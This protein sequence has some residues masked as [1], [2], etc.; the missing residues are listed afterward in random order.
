MARTG[1]TVGVEI[2]GKRAL[3]AKLARLGIDIHFELAKALYHEGERIMGESKSTYVPVRRGVLRAS[4]HVQLPQKGPVVY[5]GYG[6]PAI[7]YAI[8]QHETPPSKYKHRVGQWKYLE[9]PA[10]R[11]ATTMGAKIAAHLRATAVA[12]AAR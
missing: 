12:R 3:M 8:V 9:V 11:A 2:H 1:V 5:L 10:L 6:G 4:G 7:D